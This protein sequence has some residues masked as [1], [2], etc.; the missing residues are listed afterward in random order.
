MSSSDYSDSSSSDSYSNHRHR[1][2]K[3]KSMKPLSKRQ[4][5]INNFMN[6]IVDPEYLCKPN[7]KKPGQFIVTKR[8]SPLNIPPANPPAL[9]QASTAVP[10]QPPQNSVPEKD[11]S[12][13]VESENKK[14]ETNNLLTKY[15]QNQDSI[16]QTFNNAI[17]DLKETMIKMDK[18]KAKRKRREA[19]KKLQKPKTTNSKTKEIEQPMREPSIEK[20][21][22]PQIQNQYYAPRR[23]RPRDIINFNRY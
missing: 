17:M 21:E 19:K 1:H 12:K 22:P 10:I 2:K 13:P 11:N 16:N 9:I 6:G 3:S 23:L 20:V 5:V 4:Q 18:E 15:I 14:D 7:K 8:K